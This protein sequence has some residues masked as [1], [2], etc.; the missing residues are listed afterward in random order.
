M[1]TIGASVSV[2]T[3][4]LNPK[5]DFT[6]DIKEMDFFSSLSFILNWFEELVEVVLALRGTNFEVN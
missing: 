6:F 2:S 5:S 1:K 3:K 4:D